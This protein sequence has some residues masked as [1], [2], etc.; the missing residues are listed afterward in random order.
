MAVTLILIVLRGI[1]YSIWRVAL[2]RV[3]LHVHKSIRVLGGTM[4][5][6]GFSAQHDYGTIMIPWGNITHTFG[7]LLKKVELIPFLIF[8]ESEHDTLYYIEGNSFNYKGLLKE[9]YTVKRDSNF[10]NMAKKFVS[11][12]TRTYVDWSLR[13]SLKGGVALLPKFA[14]LQKLTEHCQTA[15]I[16]EQAQEK[17]TEKIDAPSEDSLA[18]VFTRKLDIF[19]SR[20]KDAF[21][22]FTR[23]HGFLTKYGKD[24]S[25]GPERQDN[26][27]RAKEELERSLQVDPF[28]LQSHIALGELL[29]EMGQ[30]REAIE[31]FKRALDVDPELELRSDVAY[32]VY[33][34]GLTALYHMQ[35]NSEDQRW[36]LQQ[37][38]G[39]FHGGK[40]AQQCARILSEIDGLDRRWYSYYH[41]G[42]E[43][44]EKKSYIRALDCLKE[45]I[46]LYPGYRWSYHWK[47]K[48]LALLGRSREALEN[49][50]QADKCGY[51]AMTDLEI[52]SLYYHNNRPDDAEEML[53]K[54]ITTLPNF[55]LPYVF[56]GKV[57]FQ[58]RKEEQESFELF[59]KAAEISPDGSFIDAL[60]KVTLEISETQSRRKTAAPVERKEWGIGSVID[61]IY[62]VMN[63]IKGG[64][65]IV[66]IV[67]DTSQS[68]K[69]A[70]KSFQEQFLWDPEIIGMFVREA[71]VW[72]RLGVHRNIVQAEQVKNLEGKPY[73]FLEY[74]EG[75]DLEEMLEA[76][77]LE[78][79][80]ATELALQFCEGMEYAFNKLGV[81]HRDIKPSNCLINADGVLKI[82]DFGLARI[83]SEEGGQKDEGQKADRIY[84]EWEEGSQ[85][86]SWAGVGTYPYTAPEQLLHEAEVTTSADIYSFGAM[87]YE[88][89]TGSPPFGKED[90]DA[91]IHGHLYEVPVDPCVVSERVPQ[92]LGDIIMK[93]LRKEPEKRF[94]SFQEIHAIL[95]DFYQEYFG[96]AFASSGAPAEESLDGIIRKGESM[97]TL[98]RLAEALALFDEALALSP[99]SI[100]ALIAKGEAL[101]KLGKPQEA[102]AA[103]DMALARE[104]KNA[105]VWH[106]RGNIFSLMKKFNDASACYD[107]ALSYSPRMAEVWSKKGTLFDLMGH[108]KEAIKCYDRALSLNPKL[109]EAWNNRGNLLSRMEKIQEAIESYK[110]AIEANPRY[111]MAW[112]NKGLLLQK[113]NVHGEAI[114]S[115][116]R[117]LE[118]EPLFV[119]ALV[120]SGMSF[121]KL[122]QIEKSLQCIDKALALEPRDFQFWT[123]KGNCLYELG[124]LEESAQCFERALQINRNN[125][126]A[127]ISRGLIMGEL[128]YF[129]EA[130]ECYEK[131]LELNPRNDFVRKA[132]YRLAERKRGASSYDENSAEQSAEKRFQGRELEVDF[133]DIEKALQHHTSLLGFFPDDP[134]LWFRKGLILSIMGKDSEALSNF[135]KSVRLDP[136]YS[137]PK[138]K[139]ERLYFAK[140]ERE[141]A[142]RKG[143]ILDRLVGK[144][145]VSPTQL[146]HEGKNWFD[147]GDFMQALK[148]FKDAIHYQP[149]MLDP[150]N[151]ACLSIYRLGHYDEAL[152][153]VS[154]ALARRP[155][156]CELWSL[157]GTIFMEQGRFSDALEA[158]EIALKIYPWNFMAWLETILCLENVSQCNRARDYAVKAM[159]FLEREYGSDSKEIDFLRYRGILSAILGRYEV[160]R[161]FYQEILAQIPDD[162]VTW[163]LMGDALF[164]LGRWE[165]ALACFEKALVKDMLNEKTL[166]RRALCYNKMGQEDEAIMGLTEASRADP[167]FEWPLYYKGIFLAEKGNRKAAIQYFNEVLQAKAQSSLLWQ[168]RGIFLNRQS[169][170]T[171][172][173]WSFDKALG[174]NPWDINFWLNKG[175]ILNKLGRP[176]DATCCFERIL[177]IDPDDAR[178][179]FFKALSLSVM[180]DWT[181]SIECCTKAIE[182]NPRLVDAWLLKGVLLHNVEKFQEAL[183]CMDKGLEL[184]PERAEIW[185][186][187]GVLL[188]KIEKL[189]DAIKCYNKALEI[190]PRLA[191]AW[192]NKG[193]WLSELNRLEEA[194]ECYDQVLD[195]DGKSAPAWRGKGDCHYELGRLGEAQRCYDMSLRIEPISWQCWNSKGLVLSRMGRW[196]ESLSSFEKA[197]ELHQSEGDVWSNK[198]LTLMK[199]NRR[200]ESLEA[201]D[202]AIVLDAEDEVAIFN[203]ITNLKKLQRYK[204]AEEEYR[205]LLEMNPDFKISFDYEEGLLSQNSPLKRSVGIH[206]MM[207]FKLDYEL[208]IKR[209]PH[210]FKS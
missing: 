207:E 86:A 70:L 18:A 136:I 172:A 24:T 62:R 77:P 13:D 49:Y 149:E 34:R 204:K 198:G 83:F 78:P 64:M 54:V 17:K 147:R 129:G 88:M 106:H 1:I 33:C 190:D 185:N 100:K 59:L 63:V 159:Y 171:D 61:D 128:L 158:F 50:L 51:D 41:D 20:R 27:L 121:F 93:C 23:A 206:I 3:T 53:R 187:R 123:F 166:L 97:L 40:G 98:G 72:V 2:D 39:F 102:M 161:I 127:W 19:R 81:I 4:S 192:L 103:L 170:L 58:G 152:E 75:T 183:L 173:L 7:A 112:F 186:N 200:A 168:A 144:E 57:L 154:K 85:A 157:K 141:R 133:Q 109:S 156:T 199:L 26:L 92:Q 117:V 37:Y 145:K 43:M 29:Q 179:W 184:D 116:N 138:L 48:I 84:T 31:A 91:C 90:F 174:L 130:I 114:E 126:Q 118:L 95:R 208:Q 122:N 201:F 94:I 52:A 202:T 180:R 165:D 203:R 143:G 47:G 56:L 142:G 68:T 151:Y 111:M 131:A 110:K 42:L 189:E 22:H 16:Q 35:G 195:V 15:K 89:V 10:L 182:V 188:R 5:A 73:I 210:F 45:T 67:E 6:H 105:Q 193:H 115:F 113:L 134:V 108:T 140:M 71:E 120:G 36:A 160:A 14:D 197:L 21:R 153:C 150:W 124:R 196:E 132:L 164:R 46:A 177:E 135:E 162:W 12:A 101:Y 32:S 44:K 163:N 176:Q 82:T 181:E 104:P 38:L 209:P 175:I 107:K 60:Q 155:L 137:A 191:V 205:K 28:I 9:E 125:V 146:F 178:V 194:I 87:L 69:Y 74:I 119:K 79:Q 11:L 76:G 96:L 30:Y 8:F 139:E 55:S 25:Y 65:G 169:Q 66:Y 99:D 148:C 167:S 80:V